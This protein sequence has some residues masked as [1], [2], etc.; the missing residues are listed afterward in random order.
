MEMTTEETRALIERYYA[1][2]AKGKSDALI[3]LLAPDC[4]WI[5]PATA[6][7]APM[8]GA[9]A[10]AE[11]LGSKVVRAMFD[12][13]KPFSLDIH[14]TIVEGGTAVVR[15]RIQASAFNG[16]DYDNEYCWVYDC[17]DGRITRMIEY[18]DT[19]L[20]SRV[21]GWE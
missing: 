9:E 16:N 20:A 4:E 12:V 21:M 7:F 11:Q 10:I 1:T 18:A 17:A 13:S 5:P 3:E 14:Q 8:T 6:P 2:L 19:L 15:Q